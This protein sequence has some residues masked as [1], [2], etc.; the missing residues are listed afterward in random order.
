LRFLI[1]RVQA[2]GDVSY[3][4]DIGSRRAY[5]INHPE[6]VKR[7]VQENTRCHEK[8]V[9][10]QAF[11][12]VT[13]D[14]LVT[15]RGELW[16]RQRRLIQPA[17]HRQHIAQLIKGMVE[18]IDS[19]LGRWD[20]LV[21]TAEPINVVSEARCLTQIIVVR[22]MFSA[23]ISADA[24]RL[25]PAWDCASAEVTGRLWSPFPFLHDLPTPS[26]RRFQE[27][28]RT[29]NEIVYRCIADR[30]RSGKS[31]PDL[32]SMLMDARDEGTG[33]GMSDTLLRDELMTIFFGGQETTTGALCFAWHLLSKHPEIDR[34]LA[35]EAKQV[36]GDRLPT[37][38]DLPR[39]PYSKMVIDETLRI[40]PPVWIYTRVSTSDDEIGGYHIPAGSSV[41]VSPYTTHRHPGFWR[42]P[43]GFDPE[44]FNPARPSERPRYAYFPFGGG[45]RQ[46]VGNTFALVELQLALVMAAQRYRL[47]LVPGT[48]L[49]LNAGLSL[50]PRGD[51]KMTLERRSAVQ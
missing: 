24:A 42:N 40:Y 4:G 23:D 41:F 49:Q 38:E 33:A 46:C 25:I 8:G 36:L 44:R 51:I 3:L 20:R 50:I 9:E 34:R 22:A 39:L 18:N 28:L 16:Q 19:M 17:F 11:K 31:A 12:P 7:V 13:G 2:Y 5:L 10:F 45:P 35:E 37:A 30:R 14:G 47:S 32:L 48:V 21:D 43:E 29:L 26:N 1:E 27:A 6:H 15:S